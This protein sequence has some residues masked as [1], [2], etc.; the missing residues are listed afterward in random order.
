VH[1]ESESGV[2]VGTE[3]ALVDWVVLGLLETS[4]Y[5]NREQ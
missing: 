5:L 1:H 2:C 4:L 3:F